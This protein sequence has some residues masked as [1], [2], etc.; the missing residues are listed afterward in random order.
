MEK[1]MREGEAPGRGL[2]RSAKNR[3][4]EAYCSFARGWRAQEGRGVG[5][6]YGGMKNLRKNMVKRE[7]SVFPVGMGNFLDWGGNIF[8]NSLD[9]FIKIIYNRGAVRGWDISPGC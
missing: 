7:I 3:R 5:G 2:L 1:Q 6:P 8:I 4:P 9:K